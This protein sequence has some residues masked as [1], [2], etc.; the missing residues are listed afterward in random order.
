MKWLQ[1]TTVGEC[2]LRILAVWSVIAFSHPGL[3]PIQASIV[4]G[5][6]FS[7]FVLCTNYRPGKWQPP[8]FPIVLIVLA[9]ASPVWAEVWAGHVFR[10]GSKWAY[11]GAWA[12]FYCVVTLS[13]IVFAHCAGPAQGL[14][15]MD[16]AFKTLAVT[17]VVMI[18][19]FPSEAFDQRSQY[20]GTLSGPFTHKNILGVVLVLGIV[21]ALY[22]GRNRTLKT[23]VWIKSM[24]KKKSHFSSMAERH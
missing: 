12:A 17:T 21:T 5:L 22:A 1:T 13:A 2:G 23:L 19:A 6:L 3:I 7:L 20:V 10:L 4:V 8:I 11:G 24:P 14:R 18:V 9:T 15:Y 16:A